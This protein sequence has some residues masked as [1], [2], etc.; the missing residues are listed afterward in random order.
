MLPTCLTLY[1]RFPQF[2]I[3]R[4]LTF[5]P[6]KRNLTSRALP[7]SC[8]SEVTPS[9]LQELYGIPTTPATQS[10]NKIGVSGFIEEFANQADLKVHTE[11]CISDGSN[12][13]GL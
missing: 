10:S 6:L 2:Q 4:P 3:K 1:Y 13:Q 7:S 12:S 8:A 11:S 5:K 9:C